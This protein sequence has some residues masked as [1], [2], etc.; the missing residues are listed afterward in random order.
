M[1]CQ[2]ALLGCNLACHVGVLMLHFMKGGCNGIGAW[3]FNSVLNG[4]ILLLFLNFYLKIHVGK[5][6]S[7]VKIMKQQPC[8]GN[9]EGEN[10]KEKNQ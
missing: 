7:C 9:L 10:L 6:K 2:I 4:A 3:G 1:N 5:T 8:S